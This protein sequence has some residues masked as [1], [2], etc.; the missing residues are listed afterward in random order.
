MPWFYFSHAEAQ[1]EDSQHASL[2][3][4]GD[5]DPELIINRTGFRCRK[6]TSSQFV[7]SILCVYL[8]RVAHFTVICVCTEEDSYLS[9][10]C[11]DGGAQDISSPKVQNTNYLL[12][13]GL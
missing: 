9:H 2:P 8:N 13:T 11:A 5:A 7:A 10:M 12:F 3:L 4:S 1:Q 6:Q